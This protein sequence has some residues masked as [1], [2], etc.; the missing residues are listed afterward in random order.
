MG[1]LGYGG[2]W[3]I[4]LL[5]NRLYRKINGLLKLDEKEYCRPQKIGNKYSDSTKT[6]RPSPPPSPAESNGRPLIILL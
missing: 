3:S 5:G 1:L 2:N 4:F 6:A